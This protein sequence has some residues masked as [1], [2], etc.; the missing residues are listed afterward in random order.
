MI[1]GSSGMVHGP[2]KMILIPSGMI[3][4]ATTPR[5]SIPTL[6]AIILP[7]LAGKPVSTPQRPLP[8]AAE[9]ASASTALEK[10]V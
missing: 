10:A 9:K 7:C 8:Y 2:S 5:A 6:R 4:Y 1:Q 3:S